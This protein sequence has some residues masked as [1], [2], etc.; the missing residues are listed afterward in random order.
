MRLAAKVTLAPA[1]ARATA[2]AAPIPDDAPVT[3]AVLPI[4]LKL[5]DVGNVIGLTVFKI[6]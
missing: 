1:R 4:K 3:R 5:G 2:H 6:P